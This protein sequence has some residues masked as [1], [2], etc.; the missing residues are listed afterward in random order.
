MNYVFASV[1]IHDVLALTWKEQDCRN[2][3]AVSGQLKSV[4]SFC[5]N[6]RERQPYNPTE[7]E[8]KETKKSKNKQAFDNVRKYGIPI[9]VWYVTVN[10]LSPSN[11]LSRYLV[12]RRSI[13]RRDAGKFSVLSFSNPWQ[14]NLSNE[15][16]SGQ[17]GVVMRR[18]LWHDQ[19]SNVCD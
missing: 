8:K 17:F 18:G 12:L 4:R 15:N 11:N 7:K 10:K 9:K 13:K 19:V 14:L 2:D 6:E 1:L 5:S 16:E 3:A